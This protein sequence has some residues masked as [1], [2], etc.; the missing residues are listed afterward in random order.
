LAL[1][2]QIGIATRTTGDWLAPANEALADL[3][4]ARIEGGGGAADLTR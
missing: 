2:T 3:R 1:A 4:A